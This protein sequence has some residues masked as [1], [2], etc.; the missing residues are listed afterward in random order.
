MITMGA[1]NAAI[2]PSSDFIQQLILIKTLI[3][4]CYMLTNH[5]FHNAHELFQ[6]KLLLL[7]LLVLQI[8][9]STWHIIALVVLTPTQD[10]EESSTIQ[11]ITKHGD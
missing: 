2:A 10:K 4:S 8:S 5:Q 11:F 1:M 7:E 9:I 6:L 3:H